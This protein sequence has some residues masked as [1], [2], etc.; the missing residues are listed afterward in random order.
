MEIYMDENTMRKSLASDIEL[1]KKTYMICLGL[2][3]DPTGL[4]NIMNSEFKTD[5][6]IKL[7]KQYFDELKIKEKTI[8][9]INSSFKLA[10][11]ILSSIKL[12]NNYL[13]ELNKY[14]INRRY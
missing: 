3:I 9:E 6:K 10:E 11:R 1:N 2:E 14:L 8:E 13:S 5:K 12:K 4:G 7:L